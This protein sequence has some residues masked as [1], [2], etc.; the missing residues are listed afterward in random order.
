MASNEEWIYL[1][2]KVIDDKSKANAFQKGFI[3]LRVTW[4]AVQVIA[5]NYYKL[6]ITILE[7]STL[8]HAACALILYAF[9]FKVGLS[10]KISIH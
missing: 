7:Y 1:K 4:M 2:R 10:P 3:L 6:P 5:R 8:F 9:W